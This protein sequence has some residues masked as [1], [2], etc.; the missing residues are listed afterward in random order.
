[1][2]RSLALCVPIT[3]LVSAGLSAALPAA[4]GT[5]LV[6]VTADSNDGVCDAHCSLREAIVA[7]N[8]DP[9]PDTVSLPADVPYTLEIAGR[10]EDASATGDLDI[11]HIM[12]LVGSGAAGTIIDGGALDRV[13][14]IRPGAVVTIT[15]VTIQNG[16]TGTSQGENFGG[17]IYIEEGTLTLNDSIVQDCTVQS[18]GGGIFNDQ[19]VLEVNRS[20]I[21]RNSAY[22]GGGIQTSN[23]PLT[24]DGST[25]SDNEATL[26]GGGI[27]TLDT[28]IVEYPDVLND[29]TLYGN[30][31]MRGGG[32]YA[33]GLSLT[34][35]RC[36]VEENRSEG[37]DGGGVYVVFGST[38]TLNECSVRMN[39]GGL[40]GGF[41]GGGGLLNAGTLIVNTTTVRGNEAVARG[42][43]IKTSSGQVVLT[44]S[45][46]SGNSSGEEG[47]GIA[48][49]G[50]ALS[51]ANSTLSHNT[52]GTSEGGTGDNL[53]GL[54]T[55]SSI[56]LVNTIISD[57]GSGEAGANCR[58]YAPIVTS[59]GHNLADDDSCSLGLAS[60]LE[61]TDAQLLVLADNGGP[62]LT[63]ALVPGSPAI[64]G[65]D[66]DN[67]LATDQRGFTRPAD[68]DGDTFADC[69]IGAVEHAA[70][71]EPSS[72]LL[73]AAAL[74]CLGYLARRRSRR[75]A[76]RD[77]RT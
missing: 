21:R 67:C 32:I 23:G 55:E 19:G 72:G 17:G 34:L 31:A 26:S 40:P 16:D 9:D 20:T 8:S 60:D 63:H 65:G 62:T 77:G 13:I 64:D 4:A 7:A 18:S 54:N 52:A 5:Y 29:T 58:V 11:A 3:L 38:V 56:E 22:T 68:G 57:G 46:V 25:V 66:N 70:V 6:T 75:R 12:Q 39:H 74:A 24:L 73:R 49:S 30:T 10:F 50:G 42:G 15:G 53:R 37:D 27:K 43:G 28:T 41:H 44:N 47:G 76:S 1:M 33:Q 48:I 36:T 45:T 69:D 35:N 61:S 2:R 14:D 51:I 71:P 59:L